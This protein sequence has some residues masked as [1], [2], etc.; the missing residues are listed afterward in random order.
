MVNELDELLKNELSLDDLDE[1]NGGRIKVAGYGL[2][3]AMM[4]MQKKLGNSKEHCIQVL[5]SGW[6]TDCQF[7]TMFTD[8]TGDDLQKAIDYIEKYW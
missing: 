1:I 8:Q 5:I 3:T 7:K 2:L 6:E 4:A